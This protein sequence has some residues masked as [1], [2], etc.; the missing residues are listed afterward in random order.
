LKIYT[1]HILGSIVCIAILLPFLNL[2]KKHVTFK[3]KQYSVLRFDD[4]DEGGNT[5]TKIRFSDSIFCY[6]YILKEGL[7]FPYAGII[8]RPTNYFDLNKNNQIT[9]EVESEYEKRIFVQ[10]G[11]TNTAGKDM[12]LRKGVNIL[13]GNHQYTVNQKD[14]VMPEWFYEDR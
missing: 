11:I 5:N 14:L 9:F 7:Q 6:Q 13:K 1:K 8:I 2:G 10:I 3:E 4:S 12:R